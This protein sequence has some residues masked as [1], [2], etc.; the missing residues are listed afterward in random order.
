MTVSKIFKT[1]GIIAGGLAAFMMVS[2]ESFAGPGKGGAG[3]GANGG[4]NGGGNGGNGGGMGKGGGGNGGNGG[5][6][7]GKGG[8]GNGGNGGG[9]NAGNGGECGSA[10]NRYQN[11][12]HHACGRVVVHRK[13]VRKYRVRTRKVQTRKVYSTTWAAGY[14]CVIN[15]APVYKRR[16]CKRVHRLALKGRG[17]AFADSSGY[18]SYV[19]MAAQRRVVVKHRRVVKHRVATKQHRVARRRQQQVIY[20][21]QAP[22]SVVRRRTRAQKV[23]IIQ[24]GMENGG[25]G[26]GNGG[27]TVHYGPLITK[28]A[29]Y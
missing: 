6:G 17:Y 18:A 20:V 12:K 24:G 8:G 11:Y 27:V 15:G 5:G 21:D 4:G 2:A 28:Q 19:S 1:T 25:Y 22:R 13:K 23:I 7:M 3:N 14:S 26:Y 10:S 16:T 29:P 9:G